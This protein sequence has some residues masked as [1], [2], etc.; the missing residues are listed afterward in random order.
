MQVIITTWCVPFDQVVNAVRGFD[1]A[2][3]AVAFIN[4]ASAKWWHENEGDR[5]IAE[6]PE[7]EPYQPI[8]ELGYD[9]A[10]YEL[11]GGEQGF[12]AMLDATSAQRLF[13]AHYAS[14]PKPGYLRAAEM[15]SHPKTFKV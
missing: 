8:V 15:A 2:A 10:K 5:C 9:I 13:E 12:H 7:T 4:A 1:D 14:Q 6:Y 3:S 11:W